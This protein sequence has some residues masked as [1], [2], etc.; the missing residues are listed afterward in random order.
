[1]NPLRD[2]DMTID[3]SKMDERE[4]F[5]PHH[6]REGYRMYF[7]HGINPGS[8][9]QAIL[10]LDPEDAM[11]RADHINIH[12]IDSQINWVKKYARRT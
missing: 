10:N 11:G 8:F 1:M 3:Y 12:H 7:E 4:T 6:M 5:V 9:G 2:K